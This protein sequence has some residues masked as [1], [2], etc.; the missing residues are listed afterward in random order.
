VIQ[1][2]WSASAIDELAD[3]VGYIS[4]SDASAAERVAGVLEGAVLA[5]AERPVGRAGR[6]PGTFEK[7]VTNL[8]YIIAYALADDV[9]EGSTLIVLHI[10][11]TARNWPEGHWPAGR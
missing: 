7:V 6:V 10:I 2:V 4:R 3:I 8:P 9:E 1:V 11:H 5:L